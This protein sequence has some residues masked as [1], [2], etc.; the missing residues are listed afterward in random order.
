MQRSRP[1]IGAATTQLTNLTV[2]GEGSFFGRRAGAM[3]RTG[4]VVCWSGGPSDE[5]LAQTATGSAHSDDG[6][7]VVGTAGRLVKFM[8]VDLQ[9]LAVGI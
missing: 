1:S 5:G 2:P 9:A 8:A 4:G 7:F 6:G 3:P